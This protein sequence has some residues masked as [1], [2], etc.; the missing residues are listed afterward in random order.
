MVD[1][2][3][4]IYL[5]DIKN[6]QQAREKGKYF[7]KIIKWCIC[8][9][10]KVQEL[11]FVIFLR[12]IFFFYLFIFF[13]KRKKLGEDKSHPSRISYLSRLEEAGAKLQKEQ[14]K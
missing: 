10:G 4:M 12:R 7:I 13:F 8:S 1:L 6:V 5:I 11:Y 9:W 2:E 3:I 14:P